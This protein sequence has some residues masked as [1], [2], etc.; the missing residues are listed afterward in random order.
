MNLNKKKSS[1]WT[2]I[3]YSPRKNPLNQNKTSWL[4]FY[5]KRKVQATT[6]NMFKIMSW[7]CLCSKLCLEQNFANYVCKKLYLNHKSLPTDST[8]WC[9]KCVSMNKI[10]QY[11]DQAYL[12][13]LRDLQRRAFLTWGPANACKTQDKSIREAA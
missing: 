3:N 9:P 8:I 13:Y 11:S 5:F 1:L 4:H 7:T 2:Q 6:Y 12:Y 10:R